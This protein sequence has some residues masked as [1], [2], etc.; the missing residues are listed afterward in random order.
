MQRFDLLTDLEEI[1]IVESF[2]GTDRLQNSHNR[3]RQQ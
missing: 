3:H 1:T 2:P